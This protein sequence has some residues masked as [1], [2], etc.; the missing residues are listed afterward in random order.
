MANTFLAVRLGDIVVIELNELI[1]ESPLSHHWWMGRVIH[2]VGGAR[3]P[4]VNTLFQV[5]DVDTGLI[6]SVNADLVKKILKSNDLD[7]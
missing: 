1:D 3:N 5:A 4:G 6:R 2:I 7:L